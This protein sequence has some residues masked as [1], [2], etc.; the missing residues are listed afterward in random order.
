MEEEGKEEMVGIPVHNDDHGNV[1]DH[2]D[3]FEWYDEHG[4]LHHPHDAFTGRTRRT[5]RR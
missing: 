5:R 3:D 4:D 2:T 1:T